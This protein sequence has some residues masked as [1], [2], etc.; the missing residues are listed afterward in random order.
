MKDLNL[1]V[2]VKGAKR[3]FRGFDLGPANI[4]GCVKN[5]ALEVAHINGIV[6]DEPKA[7]YAGGGQIQGCWRAQASCPNDQHTGF[8][9]PLL[10]FH[11][12]V[13]QA[14]VPSMTSDINHGS[15]SEP[16][17]IKET[18]SMDVLFQPFLNVHG[19]RASQARSG[20]GLFVARVN[21]IASSEDTR[22]GRHGVFLVNDVTV[23]VGVDLATEEIGNWRMANGDESSRCFN[24]FRAPVLCVF[25]NSSTEP[26]FIGQPFL[27]LPEGSNLNFWI[28]GRS[29]VHDGGRLEDITAM[30]ERDFAGESGEEGRFLAGRISATDNK[31]V[32]ITEERP[33]AGRTGRDAAALLFGF[34]GGIQPNGFC[35]RADNEGVGKEGLAFNDD[36]ERSLAEVN[37]FDVFVVN[38]QTKPF[39]LLAKLHHHLWSCD[40]LRIAR[41][42]L[43]VA[44]KHQL[45]TRHVARKHQWIEHRTSGVKPCSVASWS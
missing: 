22:N 29:L 44:S 23:F 26:F 9:Q 3:F 43:Y 27:D 35:A 10:A 31:H 36:L 19:R 1:H 20:D 16:P 45:T 21:H 4:F 33:I 15:A 2:G 13:G 14:D 42:V 41:E 8:T 12:N 18:A 6:V 39:S 24:G 7:T 38:F 25:Q 37:F 40:A 28:V 11:P 5:L 30:N 32:L 34:T 17:H